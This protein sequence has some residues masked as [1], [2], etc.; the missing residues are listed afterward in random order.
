MPGCECS[1]CKSGFTRAYV[2]HL[3]REKE[4]LGM[5]LTSIHNL[6]FLNHLVE[7]IRVEIHTDKF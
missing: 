4:M 6:W 3:I 2:S 7:T 5:R 1:T